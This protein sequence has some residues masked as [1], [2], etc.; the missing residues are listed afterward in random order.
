MSPYARFLLRCLPVVLVL[1]TATVHEPNREEARRS[2][3]SATQDPIQDPTAPFPRKGRYLGKLLCRDC[4]EDAWEAIT[5]G[6]HRQVV[7]GEG[8]LGCETC[9]GPGQAHG[10]DDDNDP[11]LITHPPTLA[12]S[13]QTRVCV[14]CHAEQVAGHGGEPAGFL[15]AAKGCTSCHRVHESTPEVPHPGIAFRTRV[16]ANNGAE[17]VGAESCASCHPIRD[18]L[19]E[20][21]HHASLAAAEDATGCEACHGAGSLHAETSGVARLITRPDHAADGIATCRSCHEQVHPSEFHWQDRPAPLLSDG[22][23]CTT[24]HTV[25]EATETPPPAPGGAAAGWPPEIPTNALCAKC[26]APAF[27]VLPGTIHAALGKR[28]APLTVGCGSCHA[29]AEEHARSGGRADLVD[30]LRGTDARHQQETC[31]SCHQEQSR[32]SNIGSHL[33]NEVTCLTCHSPA[34]P[35]NDVRGDAERKCA[36]CHHDVAA[37]FRLPNHHPVPEGRMGCTDCHDPHSSRPRLRDL[38][39]RERTCTGCH[40]QY[41]GPFV[42]AHQASRLDGCVACHEPHGASNRRMLQQHTTQQNCLQCH[43]DF[44][45]FHDQTTGAVF[46]NCLNCHT[47]VHGSNHSR[48]LFR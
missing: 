3:G 40:K 10:E 30:S 21:S 13:V 31:A 33:R 24:C 16:A 22:M 46:T 14:A 43:A 23:T 17:P 39:L 15:E 34:A 26:H 25:H 42:F 1:S 12:P 28:D 47:E 37:Q 32:H 4:H 8:T 41:Q 5:E 2:I 27:D 19:L 44:P 9:H 36:S 7:H 35:A 38:R 29:G 18:R 20:A 45:S 11:V 6:R 48:F